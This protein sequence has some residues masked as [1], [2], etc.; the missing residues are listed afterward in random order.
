[1]VL[2]KV[3]IGSRGLEGEPCIGYDNLLTCSEITGT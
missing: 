2:Y 1:M 3:W